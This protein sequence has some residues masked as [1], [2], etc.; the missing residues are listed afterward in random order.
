L[1]TLFTAQEVLVLISR[2]SLL[3]HDANHLSN[4]TQLFFSMAT[5]QALCIFSTVISSESASQ[6][7]DEGVQLIVRINFMS[8]CVFG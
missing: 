7:T 4:C 2:N 8:A 3:H 1:T 6:S 5:S